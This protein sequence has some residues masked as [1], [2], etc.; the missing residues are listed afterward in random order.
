MAVGEMLRLAAMYGV[1]H[2]GQAALLRRVLGHAAG[3]F[4]M[5]LYDAERRSAPLG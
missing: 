4:D 5:I 2:R 3:N 1:H